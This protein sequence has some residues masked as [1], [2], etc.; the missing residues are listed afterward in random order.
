MGLYKALI[1]FHSC[2][3][4]TSAL[5]HVVALLVPSSNSLILACVA[6]STVLA[7]HARTLIKRAPERTVIARGVVAPHREAFKRTIAMMLYVNLRICKLVG[8]LPGGRVSYAA[9]LA[10]GVAQFVPASLDQGNTWVFIVPMFTAASVDAA[11]QLL[12]H[13]S[14][15]LHLLLSTQLAALCMSFAFTL[16]FRRV[17]DLFWVYV[18]AAACV[19]G[20]CFRL[21]SGDGSVGL[22]AAAAVAGI[23]AL[24]AAD[25]ARDDVRSSRHA[26]AAPNKRTA[27]PEPDRKVATYLR[28]VRGKLRDAEADEDAT[29]TTPPPSVDD[30]EAVVA[31]VNDDALDAVRLWAKPC[32]VVHKCRVDRAA[33]VCENLLEF[34]R[35]WGWPLRF[36][37]VRGLETALRS[38][39]HWIL[40]GRDRLDRRVLTYRA[41]SLS[42]APVA[43]LQRMMCLLLERL[44]LAD[45]ETLRSGI[46]FLVDLSGASL[47]TLRHLALEDVKR[48]MEMFTDTFPCRLRAIYVVNLPR[49][50]R[51][52]ATIVRSL[53]PAKLRARLHV[54]HANAGKFPRLLKDIPADLVP[55]S[56]GGTNAFFDWNSIVDR[57]LRAPTDAPTRAWL[58]DPI[59]SH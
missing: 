33:E 7:V 36:D 44:T 10:V 26:P 51:P 58:D 39:M 34:R 16:G 14:H 9:S 8:V 23:L 56:M 43:D 20:R 54:S 47:K 50:L 21:V 1:G 37:D 45:G 38:D 3:G 46:V 53:L 30:V 17:L 52:L 4:C 12:G 13:G 6:T 41:A 35:R 59:K 18:W 49:V 55:V 57:L 19:V 27:S 2:L 31:R 24:L 5:L 42:A 48:G 28:Y 11:R 15:D 22:V 32:L 29:T 40:P 25:D